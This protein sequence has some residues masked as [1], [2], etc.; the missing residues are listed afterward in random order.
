MGM[1]QFPGGIWLGDFEFHPAHGREGNP[2]VPVCMVARE[3]TTGR[4]LRLWQDDLTSLKAAPFPTDDTALFVAYYA[5]AEIGCFISLGWPAPVN[6]LDLFAEFRC[7]SN[8]KPRVAGNGLLGALAAHGLDA[9]DADEKRVWRDLVLTGGPWSN[10][11]QVGILDYCET[12]VQAL[13]RLLPAMQADIDWPRALL[14]GRYSVAVAHIEA[15]GVPI[16]TNTLAALK[17][18]WQGIQ[19]SLIAA[20][21]ANYGVYD[22]AA[23]KRESFEKLLIRNGIAWPRLASGALDMQDNTF[24]DMAHMHPQLAPLRELR[25]ALSQM[26][27]S[28]LHVGDDGRNRCLLSMYGSKTGRNQPSNAKFI[29][30]PS[31]W[32]RGLIQPQPGYGVAYVDWSQQEFGIAA[33]LSGDDSMMRAY[34]SGDPYLAFAKQ[35]G[36]VPNDATKHTHA[37]E[38]AQFKACVLAVQ[39]GMGAESLA[40]RIN[41]PVARARELL[42]LHRRTY[43]HFWAWSEGVLDQALLGGRLWTTFGWQLFVDDTP[44]GRSLCNFPMQA[45][46]A[47]MLRLA[48]IRLIADGIRICAPVHDAILIEAPLAELDAVIA[49]TQ[50]V[51]RAASAAVLDGFMLESD[52]KIVRSPERYMDKR[53]IGMWNTV[54][55]QLGLATRKVDADGT[56]VT[57]AAYPSTGY[58]PIP[59]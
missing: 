27:L 46:G 28:D 26:R 30:G 1:P 51:M 50:A 34:A 48:C 29:F 55:D 3:A 14:R 58:P 33:A 32:L 24:K 11:E 56:A 21:D 9:L 47:E 57:A 37:T 54:M 36:A 40:F 10:S 13:A 52:A 2:P 38:R 35:A 43:R 53:G 17:T 22:G 5:S 16:D 23:F 42:D 8:G 12:D 39:Y 19:H 49:H 20:V 59:V 15:N 7:K 44:N 6:V 41:K 25:G 45:N 31:V 4:T 18:G